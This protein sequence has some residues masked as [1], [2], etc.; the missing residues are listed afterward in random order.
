MMEGITDIDLIVLKLIKNEVLIPD[1]S[2][3]FAGNSN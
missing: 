1:Y 3:S 2:V